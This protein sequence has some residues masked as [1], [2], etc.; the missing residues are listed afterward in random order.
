MLFCPLKLHDSVITSYPCRHPLYLQ[1]YPP[2]ITRFAPVVYV[3]ASLTRYTYAPL[4]SLACPFLFSGIMSCHS[5]CVFSSTKSERPVSMYP[6]DT[7]LTRAKSRHSLARLLAMWM[8]P[9]LATL[10]DVCSCG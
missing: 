5:F 2:S 10:Y 6:G 3:L 1:V 8:H 7:A 9:A 4:S